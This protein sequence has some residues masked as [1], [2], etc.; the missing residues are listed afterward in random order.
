ML[1]RVSEFVLAS[2]ASSHVVSFRYILLD[3]STR[4]N[5][6]GAKGFLRAEIW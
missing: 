6:L 5:I 4:G 2:L 3:I 1:M